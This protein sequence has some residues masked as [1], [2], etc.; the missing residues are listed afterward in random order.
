MAHR[1]VDLLASADHAAGHQSG[2]Q[3]HAVTTSGTK[4]CWKRSAGASACFGFMVL[5]AVALFGVSLL[6]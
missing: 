1:H 6:L 3:R 2:L 4:S 5:V